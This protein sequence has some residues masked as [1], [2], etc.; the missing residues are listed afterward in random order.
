MLAPH[1]RAQDTITMRAPP[2]GPTQPRVLT[3]DEVKEMA[4]QAET[5]WQRPGWFMPDREARK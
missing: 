2:G 5:Y 1:I 3:D 4:R